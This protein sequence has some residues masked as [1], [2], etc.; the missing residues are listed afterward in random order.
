MP[1][2]VEEDGLQLHGQ[3]E[4]QGKEVTFP[5]WRRPV[6][7][8]PHQLPEI[9]KHCAWLDV[10]QVYTVDPCFGEWSLERGSPI[11]MPEEEPAVQLADRGVV[12]Y[13]TFHYMLGFTRVSDISQWTKMS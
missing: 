10:L 11:W 9:T 7:N 13:H 3:E 12:L 8:E 4:G 2:L 5:H 1:E 6:L